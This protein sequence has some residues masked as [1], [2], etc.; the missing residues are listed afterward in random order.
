MT[1]FGVFSRSS[2]LRRIQACV[3]AILVVAPQSLAIQAPLLRTARAE[4]GCGAAPV[5]TPTQTYRLD[6]QTVYDERQVTATK[7]SYETVY[8]TKTYTVQKPVWE[9]QTQER[10]YTVQRPVWET[11]TREE[12]STVMKPVTSWPTAGAAAA[13]SRA[14]AIR[15]RALRI[16]TTPAAI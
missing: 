10:R 2:T 15:T 7:V 9:T 8:D 1:R 3:S 16:G 14:A 12:R 13:P 6:Y 5:A 4:C 11:Q